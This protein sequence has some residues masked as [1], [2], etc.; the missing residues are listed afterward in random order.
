MPTSQQRFSGPTA[1]AA[2]EAARRAWGPDV[3]I[4]AAERVA[5]PGLFGRKRYV[6]VTVEPPV[7]TDPRDFAAA[8]RAELGREPAADREERSI[9][10]QV[11]AEAVYDAPQVVVP[12][13]E[14]STVVVSSGGTVR[15]ARSVTAPSWVAAEA[16]GAA[17]RA[18]IEDRSHRLVVDL[19]AEDASEVLLDVEEPAC[20]RAKPA[21]DVRLV[22]VLVPSV[23]YPLAAFDAVCDRVGVDEEHRFVLARRRPE[24]PPGL[25]APA[26][27]VARAVAGGDARVAVL[28]DPEQLAL[29][30][31]SFLA[32]TTWV[33]AAVDGL[34]P[35]EQLE[36]ELARCGPLDALY[37][38]RSERAARHLGLAVV[39]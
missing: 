39:A 18:M 25:R 1:Q 29:L 10:E 3:R 12:R 38:V 11:Y 24:V 23:T 4:V 17:V 13:R 26:E 22:A 32:A 19:R 8:L 2:I 37:C 15:P 5:K 33:V 21:A 6:V 36:E 14:R 9:L 16:T 35:A 34:E 7:K 31:T 30:R 20:E 27:R 28:V